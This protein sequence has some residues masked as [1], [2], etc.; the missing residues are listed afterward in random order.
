MN[1]A[2]VFWH[3]GTLDAIRIAG[4]SRR[5][6]CTAEIEL[7]L[8]PHDQAPERRQ[9]TLVCSGVSLFEVSGDVAELTDN[10]SAGNVVDAVVSS[11]DEG[12]RIDMELTG[13]RLL[14]QART[15]HLKQRAP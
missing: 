1:L 15:L 5:R 6:R 2:K 4:P 9:F 10:A 8:Y 3:D 14:L 13:G 12:A 7:S 11:S